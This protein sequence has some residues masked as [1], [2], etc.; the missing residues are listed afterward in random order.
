MTAPGRPPAKVAVRVD[1][2]LF[3]VEI[4][5]APAG[6]LAIRVDGQLVDVD[7]RLDGS[8]SGSLLLDGV[9][10]VVDQDGG[11][12]E[13]TVVVDG[14]AFCAQI[15]GA[16]GRRRGESTDG[17]PGGGQRLLAP[18]PGKVVALLVAVGQSVERGAGLVV[19]EAMKMQNEIRATRGGRVARVEVVA[20][21]PVDGGARLVVLEP[22]SVA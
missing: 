7:A 2:T 22:G 3:V 19:L 10:H 18:M 9:S 4:E 1:G 14:E 16:G 6:R 11:R 21:R 17:H 20:G 8:G 5:D 12:G 13:T 15:E